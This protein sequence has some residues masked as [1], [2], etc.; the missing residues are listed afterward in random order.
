MLEVHPPQHAATTWKD[1]FI[2]IATIVIGLLI[3]V[4]L[5]QLVEYFHHRHEIAETRSRLQT[6]RDINIATFHTQT[7]EIRRYVPLLQNNLR[8]L[9]YLREHPGAPSS[10]WP[11]QLSWYYIVPTYADSAWISAHESNGLLLMEHDELQRNSELYSN[12]QQLNRDSAQAVQSIWHAFSYLVRNQ[13][14]SSMNPGQIDSAIQ[15]VTDT[16]TL[17]AQMINLQWNVHYRFADFSP[18]PDL[19]EQR[20]IF[21]VVSP[22]VDQTAAQAL[23]KELL[24]EINR[25]EE[26]A[27]SK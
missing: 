10:S 1:F 15:A 23:Q 6:E 18:A 16:L 5:E 13:D 11:G 7:R 8:I 20:K 25:I 2:H 14:P 19:E 3:A 21:H 24:D 22:A 17:Y 26:E 27:K 4:G 9:L 12:L